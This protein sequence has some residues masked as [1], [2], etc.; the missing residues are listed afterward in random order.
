MSE[1][2]DREDRND[3]IAVNRYVIL[4]QPTHSRAPNA[5]MVEHEVGVGYDEDG[6]LI[7]N[8]DVM[9]AG[10]PLREALAHIEADQLL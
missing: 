4:K 6:E 3:R 5:W 10:V 8:R 9:C 7:T 2:Q 1:T